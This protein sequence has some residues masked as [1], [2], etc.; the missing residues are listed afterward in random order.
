[1]TEVAVATRA[2]D[3]GANHAMGAI[4]D[5]FH[6][7]GQGLAKAWP[8]TTMVELGA[9]IEQR[10]PTGR[11]TI[12]AFVPH[13]VVFA[14]EWPFG[15]SLAQYLVLVWPEDLFPFLFGLGQLTQFWIGV[16]VSQY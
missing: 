13:C 2:A 1:M 4:F 7:I 11:A 5:V 16:D 6:G 12:G 10:I 8:T 14:G 15:A 3:F 9:A